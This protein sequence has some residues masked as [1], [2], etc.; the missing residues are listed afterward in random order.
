MSQEKVIIQKEGRLIQCRRGHRWIYF[1][2]S[3]FFATCPK[4]RSTVTISP[5][6][7]IKDIGEATS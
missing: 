1:G 5:K 2:K 6:R 3:Q 7:K 4:C